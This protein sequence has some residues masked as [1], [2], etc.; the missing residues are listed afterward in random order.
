MGAISFVQPPG[1]TNVLGKVKFLYPNEHAVYMH[2]TIKKGLMDKAVRVEGHH[3][4]RVA[5]P[6]KF[7]GVL[8]AE[9]QGMTS[10]QIDKLLATGHDS[11]VELKIPIPVHTTY[12]TAVADSGG[13]VEIYGDI[14]KLDAVVAKALGKD[15]KSVAVTATPATTG[16]GRSVELPTRKPAADQAAPRSGTLADSTP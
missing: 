9:D 8:L 4:P 2:D 3:C 16:A 15:V 11:A 12:F 10:E 5:N 1:P 14:Y 7:A 13:K 6:G